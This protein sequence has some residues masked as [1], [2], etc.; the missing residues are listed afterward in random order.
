MP[1]PEPAAPPPDR[2]PP[3]FATGLAFVLVGVLAIHFGVTFLWNAP[4]NPVKDVVG[5]QVSSYMR[6]FFVQNWSLFAPDPINTEEE[7]LVRAR[8]PGA[9]GD[10]E[11]TPWVSATEREWLVVDHNP[12]PSRA[13]RLS[14][15]LH[16]R[17]M[18]AWRGLSEEQRLVLTEP[19]DDMVDWTPLA[20]DLKAAPGG[21]GD[22]R[23]ATMVR[24]DRV[25][26]AY[27]TQVARSLWGEGVDAVQ[28][29]LRSTP[30]PRWPDRFGP[31]PDPATASVRQFGWRPVLV[32]DGQDDDAFARAFEGFAS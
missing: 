29:R 20:D 3:A 16:R 32:A 17:L 7:I 2:P 15:N 21:A 8:V 28:I 19:Y 9:D 26:T 18:S 1:A 11:V 5:G 12:M 10:G 24:A 31:D 22:T 14:S 27:A 23:V 30:V 13:S 25:A 4:P 6:P